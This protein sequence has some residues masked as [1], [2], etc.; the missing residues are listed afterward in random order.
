MD[1]IIFA[2]LTAIFDSLKNLVSKR[3]LNHADEYVVAWASRFFALPVLLPLL[4]V[5]E[6]PEL[7]DRFWLFLPLIVS[8]QVVATIL[9][10]RALKL[11]DLS[12]TVPLLALT[13]LFLIGVSPII[14]RETLQPLDVV[15]ILLIT[16]GTYC[17]NLKFPSGRDDGH[18]YLA[19]L[20]ALWHNPG[21]R[22]MLL[23]SFLWS[24]LS[25]LNK[26]G[27]QHSSP[28]FWPVVNS[29]TLA[30]ALFPIMM[31]RSKEVH[32][33]LRLN[34][35]ALILIGLFQGLVLACF[36]KAISLTLVARVVG[37]K[38]LSILFSVLMGYWLFNE[39][40]IR[41]RFGAASIM[42]LGVVV[43]TLA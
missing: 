40:G 18:S 33:Q 35:T 3:G 23:V 1:W 30:L 2:V 21:T 19:P 20:E 15:G 31:M 38:R 5:V 41:Q 26:V 12:L 34:L 17:L 14:V 16:G 22:L 36:M 11:A 6:R 8:I 4:W 43:M 42:L 37:V 13:P 24:V 27:I 25:T 39:Q 29:S 9:Y 28:L 32:K 7:G 10:F